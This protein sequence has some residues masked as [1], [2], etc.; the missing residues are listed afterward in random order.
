[1]R[2]RL[3]L[4]L[5]ALLAGALLSSCGAKDE[6][7]APAQPEPGKA[8]A[9]TDPSKLTARAG[10]RIVEFGTETC[11]WCDKLRAAL[12]EVNE[13]AGNALRIEYV[14]LDR[15]KDRIEEARKN[16]FE[17][18]VPFTVIYGPEGKVKGTLSGY[19]KR[20]DLVARLK[21]SGTLE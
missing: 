6:P 7:P 11:N 12:K 10:Y 17:G 5:A 16:G 4:V 15:D 1:M 8:A 18:F 3:S 2:E 14:Y 21:E 9:S 19:L 13:S 20:E